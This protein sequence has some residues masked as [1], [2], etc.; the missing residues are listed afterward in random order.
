MDKLSRRSFFKAAG[1]A[2]AG[3][4]AQAHALTAAAAPAQQAARSNAAQPAGYIFS[5]PMKPHSSK[6]LPSG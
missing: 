3:L 2:A 4:S 1:T 6:P 5:D